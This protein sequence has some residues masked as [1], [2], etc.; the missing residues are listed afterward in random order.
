MSGNPLASL[1]VHFALLSL[2]AIGGANAAI[3][4]M[5]R[6]AVEVERW[7][8]ERQFTDA[9]ALAQV[10]PGPNVII[11]TLIGY[12]VA[13]LA[14]ALVATAAMTGPTC[15]FA[16]VMTRLWDRFKDAPWRIAMQTGL[17]PV[18]IGLI[19]ASA[20][21]ITGAAVHTWLAGVIALAT[22]ALTFFTRLSPL[23]L[24]VAAAIAGL[25]GHV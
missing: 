10:S 16:Y 24:F 12:H 2:F 7:M 14:G 6:I 11:V 5:H 19:A 18:S 15:V 25:T 1:A 20:Y 21:V 3:P 23:W 8:T 22:A 4:E 17:V 9:F 13:G